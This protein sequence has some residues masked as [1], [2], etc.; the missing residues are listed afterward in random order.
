MKVR[1][2]PAA[3]ADLEAIA[4]Y[5]ARD[6]PDRALSFVR[7]LR[8]HCAGIGDAPKAHAPR[9]DLGR[10]VRCRPHGSYLILYRIV[11][12][13]VLVSRVV[14][15][16]RDVRKLARSGEVNEPRPTY[17]VSDFEALG[18]LRVGPSGHHM[19]YHV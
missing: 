14:H 13:E 17:E 12:D 1:L 4:D 8:A 15:A 7:E 16:S 19:K 11:A 9:P 2:N 5:I 10:A 6:N 3:E 18:F